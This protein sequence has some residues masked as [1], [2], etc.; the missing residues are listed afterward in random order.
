M[1]CFGF[2][3]DYDQTC[4]NQLRSLTFVNSA[5]G[6]RESDTSQR[7]SPGAPVYIPKVFT[8]KEN[9]ICS[10]QITVVRFLCTAQVTFLS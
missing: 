7:K 2:A 5:H 4:Q 3:E 9:N 10:L 8:N 6:A 1:Q